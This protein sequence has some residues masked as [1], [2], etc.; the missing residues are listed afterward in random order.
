M[1][2]RKL[3][4][5]YNV[6][7]LLMGSARAGGGAPLCMAYTGVFTSRKNFYFFIFYC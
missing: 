6:F 4:Y 2:F 1:I 5:K 7:F 3:Y